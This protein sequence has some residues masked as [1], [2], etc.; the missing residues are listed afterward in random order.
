MRLVEMK[1]T[2]LLKEIGSSSPAPGGGSVSAIMGTLAASVANMVCLITRGKKNFEPVWNDMDEYS[3][4][5][6][7]LQNELEAII[8]LDAEAFNDVVTAYK[9]PKGTEEEKIARSDAISHATEK[10]TRVPLKTM[11]LACGILEILPDIAEKGFEASISDV[12]VSA[13][14]ALGAV[15]GA[16]LNV[17]INS[18][19]LLGM[20][21]KEKSTEFMNSAS[22]FLR[23]AEEK[24]NATMQIVEKKLTYE[25]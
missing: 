11:E 20:G 1:F 21:A 9:M 18:L 10:A 15:K 17:K 13:L 12:G 5:L 7:R 4:K 16:Y 24:Y 22:K 23:L 6:Q 25:G 14:A 19:D 2:D 3:K 8:D